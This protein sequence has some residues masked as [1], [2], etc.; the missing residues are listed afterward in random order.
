MRSGPG[1]PSRRRRRLVAIGGLAAGASL[2]LAGSAQAASFTVTNLS[3]SFPAVR[4]AIADA[5]ANPDADT[6]TFASGLT[7]TINLTSTTVNPNV[8]LEI[9]SPIDLQG[10]GASQ[11][12]VRRPAGK[13]L[14]Y[15][16]PGNGQQATISGLTLTGVNSPFNGGAVYAGGPDSTRSRVTVANSVITGNTVTGSAAGG[17][18]GVASGALDVTGTTFSNNSARYGG[19]IYFYDTNDSMQSTISG[20]TFQGNTAPTGDGGAIYPNDTDAQGPIVIQ[21]STF[22]GNHAGDGSGDHGGAIYD[23]S[24]PP[25]LTITGSTISGNSATDGGGG[26]F[27]EYGDTIRDS[28]ISGNTGGGD[29]TQ[30]Y[31]GRRRAGSE[32]LQANPDGLRPD[33]EP[34]RAG[35]HRDRARLEHHRR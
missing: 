19:A 32:P 31:T 30:G 22:T 34:V 13:Q 12:T 5:N 26:V 20:D 16:H 1:G 10:P 24:D 2:A 23:F 11:I 25:V 4:Q 15:V 14:F 21:N 35:A 3:D 9:K 28:I 27:L 33:R 18:I 6:I 29:V 7:G 17:G 8:V